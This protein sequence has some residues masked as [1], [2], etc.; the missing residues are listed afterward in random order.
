[1]KIRKIK[2]KRGVFFSTDALIAILLII[3]TLVIAYPLLKNAQT[4]TQIHTDIMQVLSNL[5]V[6]EVEDAYIQSL[7]ASGEITN[8]NNT[9]LE[10]IGEFYITD[11]TKARNIADSILNNLDTTENIG[12]WYANELISSKNDTK[13][14][15]A[16]NIEVERQLISGLKEGDNVTG[17]SARAFLS[18]GLQT[19]YFYFGGYVGDGNISAQIEYDGTIS[20]ATMELSINDD[21]N[22]YVNNIYSGSFTKSS[23]T[24][25]PSTYTI[26]IDEFTSG[27]NI[28]EIKSQD[29]ES[30]YIAGGLVKITYDGSPQ[31]SE[32][33]YYFP[34]ISGII[35]LYDSIY[36]KD[37]TQMNINLHLDSPYES[38]LKIGNVTVFENYTLGEETITISNTELSSLLDYDELTNNTIPIRLGLTNVSFIAN[39][40]INSNIYSVTD[41]SGSMLDEC[42][43][44]QWS[45]LLCCWFAG[46]CND[47][48]TCNSCGGTW[49]PKLSSAKEANKAFIDGI[50]NYTG[51]KVGLTAYS[52]Q[53]IASY[54][55]P[56]S[57][58][59]TSLKSKVDS[60][61]ASGSTC[62]CC[63][64][65]SATDGLK[66]EP[67][68]KIKAMVVMSDG[69][70]NQICGIEYPTGNAKDNA[71]QAACDAYNNHGIKVYA[72][73]FGDDTDETTLQ[74]IAACGNG[75]YYY[76][77][78]D[79]IVNLYQV[80][81]QDIIIASYN[82]QTIEVN[83]GTNNTILYPDSYI[84]FNTITNPITQGII[85]NLEKEFDNT[86]TGT[87]N[88]PNNSQILNA[89]AISYSG[90]K[91][92][93]NVDINGNNTF[94]LSIYGEKYTK[95]GDPYVINIPASNIKGEEQNNSVTITTGLSP[96]N[97]SEGSNKNKIIYQ[98]IKNSTSYSSISPYISG[99]IWTIEFEDDTNIAMNIPSDYSGTAECSY[100][101][102]SQ[103][104]D[105]NDAYQKSV[106]NLLRILDS[107]QN[108]KV[109]TKFTEQSLEITPTLIE[110]IPYTWSTEVQ[111]RVWN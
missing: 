18:T 82:E 4:K 43:T 73:G 108:N 49:A 31:S 38:Y 41:V 39:N 70:A 16:R 25:E 74:Q 36:A 109:D 44:P 85:I 14:S 97:S 101:T 90:P 21:F 34:G 11:K 64:I 102:T 53:T 35:N 33:R 77:D 107:E 22:V 1:M 17:Y 75:T 95:L 71:I 28:I 55:H 61:T 8:Q 72:V 66:N 20:S 83:Q 104:Y 59:S 37:L 45:Q 12:I 5:Q 48:S 65:L 110:G 76:A 3:M 10:Q 52:A 94:K 91:W 57:D 15:D 81:A 103:N 9:I 67:A 78:V 87:F 68:D 84:S 51:N 7:I 40:T 89:K 99:C 69:E 19:K 98:I 105:L 92:T 30:L 54:G 26:P 32:R 46:G 93:D 56:L 13:F 27:T 80:I 63:G 100:T 50:L 106:F 6:G 60:W 23:S 42:S 24:T 86:T 62:I 2:N 96:T 111:I 58:D 79:E 47:F 88:I 29:N